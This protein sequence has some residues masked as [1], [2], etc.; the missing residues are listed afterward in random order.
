MATA[1]MMPQL[2]ESVVEG[3]VTRWLKMPGESSRQ[4]GTA[5]GDRHRQ[6]R[7]RG[8]GA[9]ERRCPA[10]NWWV[11]ATTVAAGDGVGLHRRAGRR[12]SAGS[13]RRRPMTCP[14]RRIF[15]ATLSRV[16]AM[17]RRHRRPL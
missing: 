3:T 13:R 5:A 11:K 12:Q 7:H 2:G 16:G 1:V 10:A 6:D 8:A 14:W 15:V 4:A 9:G 17:S